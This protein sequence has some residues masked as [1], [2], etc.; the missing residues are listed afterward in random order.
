MI[1]R[2]LGSDIYLYFLVEVIIPKVG[3][4]PAAI[5]SAAVEIYKSDKVV[6]NLYATIRGNKISVT[7]PLDAIKSTGDYI[8]VFT[9]ELVDM[10]TQTHA[11]PFR[12]TKSVLGKQ[13][14]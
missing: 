3:R 6:T 5:Q 8:A 1:S 2:K 14:Q 7:V 9:Y 10:G 13:R 12:I 4:R 11:I